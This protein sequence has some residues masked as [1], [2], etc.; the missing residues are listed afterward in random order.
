MAASLQRLHRLHVGDEVDFCALGVWL[1]ARV[2]AVEAGAS[3][4]PTVAAAA[5]TVP[6]VAAAADAAGARVCVRF[7]VGVAHASRWLDLR[8]AADRAAL[9]PA[10][11]RSCPL[12]AGQ[13]VDF[14]HRQLEAGVLPASEQWQ[15]GA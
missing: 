13:P 1:P 4:L 9:A 14:L 10:G 3:V 11:A 15:R 12:L 7:S 2:E 8:L 6:G 5:A